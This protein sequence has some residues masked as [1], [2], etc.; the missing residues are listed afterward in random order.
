MSK[1]TGKEGVTHTDRK[2]SI[3][4]TLNTARIPVRETGCDRPTEQEGSDTS[5]TAHSEVPR[6]TAPG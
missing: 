5:T 6:D 1:G 4:I 2:R 3:K